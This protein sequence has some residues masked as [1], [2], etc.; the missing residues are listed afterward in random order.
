MVFN[1]YK[2]KGAY[3]W[4]MYQKNAKYKRHVDY[5]VKWVSP[6]K[7][8]DIGAGDGLITS[9]IKAEGIDN[10]ERAVALANEKGVDVRLGSAYDLPLGRK[11]DRI[12]LLDV[13]EHLQDYK[14]ALE[15]IK[16]ILN[17]NGELYVCTPPYTGKGKY[18]GMNSEYHYFEWTPEQFRFEMEQSGF[19][20]ISLEDNSELTRMYGK[21]KL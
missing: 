21:F 5:V 1:K 7:I 18:N 9:K 12:C 6:G 10:N 11:Y 4:K 8:L 3:H 15:Q 16:K 19:R 20:T 17:V 13:I 2:E 14:L